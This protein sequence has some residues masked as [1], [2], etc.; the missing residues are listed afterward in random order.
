VAPSVR[1]P[2]AGVL[3][4]SLLVALLLVPGSMGLSPALAHAPTGGTAP[5]VSQPGSPATAP[6]GGSSS[7][8][9]ALAPRGPA[10]P[11]P[12]FPSPGPAP[13]S[14]LPPPA[15]IRAGGVPTTQFNGTSHIN[16]SLS[17]SQNYLN[18]DVNI[19]GNT[20]TQGWTET[21]GWADYGP[22]VVTGS[23]SI[24]GLN[25]TLT[26]TVFSTAP[27]S[28]LWV[29]PNAAY[30]TATS[31]M[32]GDVSMGDAAA[33]D[34]FNL[35]STGATLTIDALQAGGI[36]SYPSGNNNL[37]AGSNIA[38]DNFANS[39]GSITINGCTL[40]CPITVSP[41]SIFT[42]CYPII[43]CISASTSSI[44]WGANTFFQITGTTTTTGGGVTVSLPDSRMD[45]TVGAGANMSLTP[46]S[47]SPQVTIAPA[48]G[49]IADV[50]ATGTTTVSAG[51][52][53]ANADT[54]VQGTFQAIQTA[55]NG[56]TFY[57][58]GGLSI[59]GHIDAT[60]EQLFKHNLSISNQ[61]LMTS[62][63]GGNITNTGPVDINSA[64]TILGT[65]VTVGTLNI[66]GSLAQGPTVNQITGTVVSTGTLDTWGSVSVQGKT[67][68]NGNVT[69]SGSISMPDA[70]LPG[71][72]T[73]TSGTFVGQGSTVLV[74]T[75]VGSGT[76]T[77]TSS[78]Y[79][80]TGSVDLTGTI[81]STGTITV[82][83]THVI[84]TSGS[85][86]FHLTGT[87]QMGVSAPGTWIS[88]VVGNTYTR[89]TSFANGTGTFANGLITF[90]TGLTVHGTA[91][92]EGNTTVVGTNLLD[93]AVTTAGVSR[94]PGSVLVGDFA[95]A[96]GGSVQATGTTWVEGNISLLGVLS[97]GGGT[98]Q[99]TGTS[100]IAGTVDMD[101][102]VS[103][104]GQ[105]VIWTTPGGALKI[106][107]T[108]Q[109]GAQAGTFTSQVVGSTWTV[110]VVFSNGT[111]TF[112]AGLAQFPPG[113]S[114][115]GTVEAQGN[116]T[117]LGSSTYSGSVTTTG[118]SDFPGAA[119]EGSFALAAPGSVGVNG[120]SWVEGN[121]TLVGVLSVESGSF[122]ENGAS[123]ILGYSD[124]DGPVAIKGDSEIQTAP[125]GSFAMT[126]TILMGVSGPSWTSK[127]VGSV[128]T[129]GVIFCN[130]TSSFN[131]VT[132]SFPPGLSVHGSV[133]SSGTIDVNGA[134]DFSGAVTTSGTSQ[135]PGMSL[136]GT[137]QLSAAGGSVNATGTSDVVGDI[138][139]D[140]FL[141]VE[142]GTFREVGNSAISGS[143]TM[144]GT[145]VVNGNSQ[146]ST[147]PGTL[148]EMSGN[149]YLAQAAHIIGNVNTSGD[150]T[151]QGSAVLSSSSV[152]I[153]GSMSLDG[154]VTSRGEITLSGTAN[155]DGPVLTQGHTQLPGLG[156]A[157]NFSLH[158]GDF[159]LQ[160][161]VSLTGSTVAQGSV[162]TNSSGYF[163]VGT[164]RFDGT[165]QV[166]G[167]A[168]VNGA[169]S[170]V[171]SVDLAG[172]SQFGT[173]MEVNG[174]LD[175][176]GLDLKGPVILPDDTV[177][178]SSPANIT[179]SI[180][181]NG[182]LTAEDEASTFVGSAIINGTVT[183][184][185][186]PNFNGP[187]DLPLLGTFVALDLG[188]PLYAM[189]AALL[190][191]AV[192]GLVE[193]VR[194]VRR[195][196]HPLTDAQR[197]AVRPLRLT[198][199]GAGAGMLAAAAVGLGGTFA[200]GPVLAS[201]SGVGS[202]GS[203]LLVELV[204]ALLGSVAFLLWVTHRFL[205]TRRVR[206]ANDAPPP[207]MEPPPDA[208]PFDAPM[209]YPSEPPA[210]PPPGSPSFGRYA[211]APS[212]PV[213]PGSPAAWAPPDDTVA[214]A[215]GPFYGGAHPLS[216][217]R[218]PPSS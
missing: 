60:G 11:P 38:I 28:S 50:V 160:G 210:G 8:L 54:I 92:T 90:G 78:G 196:K 29:A 53:L 169:S 176:G 98:F 183:S 143:L 172:G 205:Y 119:L 162:V 89:G 127:V 218:P 204:G 126:A 154:V 165:T 74:G 65:A 104:S 170:T 209:G 33:G 43:G 212:P 107:S 178:F 5:A 156:V 14:P 59:V 134:T 151:I 101:G 171:G 123:S 88:Q 201:P 26:G 117:V 188:L 31:V 202:V 99:E 84:T 81:Q 35:D 6:A 206:G 97:V 146:L 18:G 121:V 195:R 139:L 211:Y 76:T 124:L 68:F 147:T 2:L 61:V 193:L 135:F 1:S 9:P 198:A 159:H 77:I 161:T 62:A 182:V 186:S 80:V 185:G 73:L 131:G 175:T 216:P 189:L 36:S 67:T 114:V 120:T 129:Q 93:G 115:H 192:A 102:P 158:W 138:T 132:A 25:P 125:G 94:F 128:D 190:L 7:P 58:S 184:S 15:T 168:T 27:G 108:I 118:T 103:M 82:T 45:V 39:T 66:S 149:I 130:G 3:L 12:G 56:G 140:G 215:P 174:D 70:F 116:V 72:F 91:W 42:P 217:R 155:F 144:T 40:I 167:V 150:V 141:L 187:V 24:V 106:N 41:G 181:E 173:W 111:S 96:A 17:S 52:S 85:G 47:G 153:N 137:F 10:S 199:G 95:L 51:D 100:S 79:T 157:G 148:L 136:V 133:A 55:M 57:N 194:L 208:S 112:A 16:G 49:F 30:P 105:A 191:C 48:S 110:G 214:P 163:V 177:T 23:I 109:M 122:A 152:D 166:T 197:Q 83:G 213:T 63:P 142:V 22:T 13:S 64:A 87:V 207:T 164:S 69:A 75:S 46:S 203:V 200:L 37:N 19:V 71:T 179:G 44:T 86:F 32:Q 145:V 180:W 4:P 113:L 34:A 21:Q 20:I